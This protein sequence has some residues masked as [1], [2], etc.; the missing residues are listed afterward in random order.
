MNHPHHHV[1]I[2]IIAT[3]LVLALAGG[4]A[5]AYVTHSGNGTDDAATA[6][7]TA[8][9]DDATSASG[10]PTITLG[11]TVVAP[12]EY[13]TALKTQRAAALNH[14]KQ[15]YGVSLSS[16]GW[17]G[18]YDGEV[19]YRWLARQTVEALKKRHAAYLIG[20]KQGLVDDDS[21]AAIVQRMNNVKRNNASAKAHGNIVYGRT[22]FDI[23]SYISYETSALKN[24]YTGDES[25]PGMSLTDEE[26]Q[27]YYDAHDWTVEG[28]DGK[29][30]LD[31]VLGNVKA[32][33]R[34]ERYDALVQ[35]KAD[36]IK[37]NVPWKQ[38][39][40]FTLQQVEKR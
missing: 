37:A 30:P 23:D 15:Q 16:A 19:P 3:V 26:V 39:Y 32:Q 35:T 4:L 34:S 25:N 8:A 17:T 36:A 1:V 27:A 18:D 13:V 38:L 11:N 40:Q 33:M 21:Y 10:F 5:I 24:S 7:G 9:I 28:V 6:D 22:T 31:Q 29:A 20:V 14:F 12:Q 2:G